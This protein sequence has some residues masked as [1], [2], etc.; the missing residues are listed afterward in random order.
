[1]ARGSNTNVSGDV[2]LESRHLMGL[3]VLMVVIFGVVF[4]LGYE[5]GRNQTG[6]KVKAADVQAGDADS[7]RPLPNADT[8]DANAPNK[9]SPAGEGFNKPAPSNQ[10]PTTVTDPGK[11]KTPPVTVT[12]PKTTPAPVV[13]TPSK[14]QPASKTAPPATSAAVKKTP[15]ASAPAPNKTAIPPSRNSGGT[16]TQPGNVPADSKSQGASLNAPLIP[17]GAYLIQVAALTKETDALEMAEALQQRKFPAFVVP[18]GADKFYHVQVG[19]YPDQ[20]SAET[21]RRALESAG[22][23]TLIKH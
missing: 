6:N 21:A 13:T 22:F 11:T 10:P 4:V 2:V 1:M 23:K 16:K 7:P 15:P 8:L 17:R 14:V 12:P 20:K 18:T 5:L 19:P 3:F 9:K